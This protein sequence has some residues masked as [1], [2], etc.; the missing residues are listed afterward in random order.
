M[1]QK[2]ASRW[3]KMGHILQVS[4]GQVLFSIKRQKM[5]CRAKYGYIEQYVS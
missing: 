3:L 1:L 2:K 4:T 5:H